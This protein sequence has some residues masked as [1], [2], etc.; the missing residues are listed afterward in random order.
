M[1]TQPLRARTSSQASVSYR[2][3]SAAMYSATFSSEVPGAAKK[4][5]QLTKVVSMPCSMKV[6]ARHRRAR[7]RAR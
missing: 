3:S 4:P 1:F 2:A 5:R 6:G 7:A